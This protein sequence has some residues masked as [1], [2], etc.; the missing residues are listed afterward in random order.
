MNKDIG[1]KLMVAKEKGVEGWEYNER[2][3]QVNR[4]MDACSHQN[5]TL[6]YTRN[7]C[8]HIPLKRKKS[9]CYLFVFFLYLTALLPTS[10]LNLQALR[11][12]DENRSVPHKPLRHSNKIDFCFKDTEQ[13]L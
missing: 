3:N 10:S 8:I 13:E 5:T 1:N 11:I 6:S 9:T 7:Y 2:E 12:L 4:E